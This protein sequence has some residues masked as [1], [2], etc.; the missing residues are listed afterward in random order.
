MVNVMSISADC[1][2]GEMSPIS[3]PPVFPP[4]SEIIGELRK[5]IRGKSR[6]FQLPPSPL[7]AEIRSGFRGSHDIKTS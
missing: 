1:S 4:Q 6:S 7:G 2:M 3:D 5:Q